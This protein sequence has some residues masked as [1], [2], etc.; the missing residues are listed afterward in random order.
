MKR[1]WSLTAKIA[2]FASAFLLLSLLSIGITLSI[3]WNLEGGAAAMNVAGRLRMMTYQMALAA[4]T[5][6]QSALTT[7]IAQMQSSLDLLRNGNQARPLFVP[8]DATIR[9]RFD[10]VEAHWQT[11]RPR[12]ANPRLAARITQHE[13]DSYVHQ[14]DALVS[15]IEHRLDFWTTVLHGF[16][17]GMAVLVVIAAL[18]MFYAAYLFVLE[19]VGRL[20]RGVQALAQGDYSARVSV[21]TTDELGDLAQGFNRMTQQLQTVY[22]ELEARVAQKTTALLTEQQRLAALYKVSALVSGAQSLT[23]LASDFTAALRDIAGADAALLRWTDEAAQRYV[24]LAAD[25][26]PAEITESERCLVAGACHCGQVRPDQGPQAIQFRTITSADAN[27]SPDDACVREGYVTLV[28]VPVSAQQR[29]LGEIDLF[30]RFT[31]Q[32]DP[33][34][35]ALFEA[36]TG[37]L[38]AAMESL[39]S[40][41][42]E[43]EAAV[44][45]ERTLLARELHDSI[46]QALAFMKIQLQLLRTGLKAH[47][48][49]Q[50]EAAVDELDAGVR[51]SLADVRELLLHF[52][53]R[54]QEQSI[55]PALRSTLQKFELQSGVATHLTFN[56]HGQPL[57]P[58]VQVQVLHV[59]QEAL[60]NVRKHARASHVRVEVRSLPRWR[61]E[62]S[63]DGIGTDLNSA[64]ADAST[65]VGLQIMRERARQ[66]N[67]ALHIE[68]QPTHGT[69]VILELPDTFRSTDGAHGLSVPSTPEPS[70]AP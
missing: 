64:P 19:P 5:A 68:S 28:S 69:R 46:A 55:E 13:V 6:D 40:A 58:D 25:C 60:S 63:D 35:T 42:L 61:I 67:A 53:T 22:T 27:Q 66:I 62:V 34:Q 10:A 26:M 33:Q 45:Q 54:A 57:D 15:A 41:A 8:W 32:L 31:H 65:H 70:H 37:H 16:Q 29:L 44:A 49:R 20:S 30:Y 18:L 14:V 59:L 56:G 43:R 7:D 1:H 11:L 9:A 12:W 36:L 50:I 4:S 23:T 2:L 51:E 38:A 21:E 52:R 39:R 24:L 17:M 47:N 48:A 3:S